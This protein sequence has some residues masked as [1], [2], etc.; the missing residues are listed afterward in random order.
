MQRFHE[1]ECA[2]RLLFRGFN[3]HG[4]P[5]N[6]ENWIPRKLP[7]ILHVYIAVIIGNDHDDTGMYSFIHQEHRDTYNTFYKEVTGKTL[8]RV[9][10]SCH[11][12]SGQKRKME[13]GGGMQ[14][15]EEPKIKKSKSSE[16]V[17]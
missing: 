4:L 15:K 3:F 6:R 1:R 17:S 13:G 10:S 14:S 12:A 5:V 16:Q 7:A 2:F 11:S 9:V 8:Q